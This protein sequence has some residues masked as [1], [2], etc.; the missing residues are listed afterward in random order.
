MAEHEHGTRLNAKWQ[1]W[2]EHIKN[3]SE[4]GK[5]QKEY[6]NE[7]G[8]KLSLFYYWNRKLK[9]R[10]KDQAEVRLVP[11]GMHPIQV[12]QSGTPLVL[13]LGHYKV[14]IGPGFDSATLGRMI[15]VL[16]QV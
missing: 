5:T 16:K 14:E 6:C 3:W 13:I 2:V 9:A 10:Q 1:Q 11:V 12:H 8:L 7:Q 4:S 15:Q